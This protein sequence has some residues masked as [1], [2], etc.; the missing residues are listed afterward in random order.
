MGQYH[1]EMIPTRL[2]QPGENPE[3]RHTISCPRPRKSKAT[4]SAQMK[5]SPSG[6]YRETLKPV[7][8]K[9]KNGMPTIVHQVESSGS[10]EQCRA[11]K[12]APKQ[13]S[14][15]RENALRRET[16]RQR[17]RFAHVLRASMSCFFS[18]AVCL[19]ESCLGPTCM[20]LSQ[21]PTH[22]AF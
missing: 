9:I 19:L 5:P 10:T 16:A 14:T 1:Q 17:A 3:H 8:R 21:P 12:K 6:T 18:T 20:S 13:P 11:R 15:Q 2:R 22:P 7:H 4:Q